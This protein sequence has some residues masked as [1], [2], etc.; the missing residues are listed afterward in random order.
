MLFRSVSHLLR[1]VR[2][3]EAFKILV[4]NSRASV[5]EVA[6]RTGFS[7]PSYFTQCFKQQYGFLPTEVHLNLSNPLED[8]TKLIKSTQAEEK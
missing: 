5:K 4:E 2:L 1:E 7:S 6:Y 8:A 3:R